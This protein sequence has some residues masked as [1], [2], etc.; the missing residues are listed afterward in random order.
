MKKQIAFAYCSALLILAACNSSSEN[1]KDKTD[2]V[3]T[4]QLSDTINTSIDNKEPVPE[5]DTITAGKIKAIRENFNRI[6]GITKWSREINKELHE[7]LEGGEATAYVLNGAIAKIAT[8][9]YGETFQV[10]TEYYIQNGQLSF[11]YEKL[12]QY[13][14]PMYYDSASMKENKDTEVFDLKKAKVLEKRS[15]FEN[16]TLFHQAT[17]NPAAIT[18]AKEL[19]AEQKKVVDEYNK[20]KA[21]IGKP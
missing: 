6:N 8:R 18:Q 16:N 1:S 11:V 7:T 14:R 9:Q 19:A 10:V 21:I 15:Y 20:I 5:T 4:S 3:A 13:N 17:S 2:T 12:L